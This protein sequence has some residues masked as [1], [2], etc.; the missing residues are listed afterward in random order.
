MGYKQDLLYPWFAIYGPAGIPEEV[1]KVLIPAIETVVKNPEHQTK[2]E[3]LGVTVEYRTPAEVRKLQESDY[4][5]AR[6]LAIQL[7]LSK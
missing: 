2:L 6:S 7:G 4:A 1:K 5:R 3:K